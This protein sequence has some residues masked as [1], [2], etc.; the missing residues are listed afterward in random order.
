MLAL[1]L[2]GTMFPNGYG[3]SG[4]S[5]ERPGEGY[6][7]AAVAALCV[8]ACGIAALQL[9]LTWV[10]TAPVGKNVAKEHA[11]E[12]LGILDGATHLN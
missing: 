1:H 2:V 9:T 3:D 8:K 12:A 10:S 4:F 11:A 5:S 7:Q 6:S